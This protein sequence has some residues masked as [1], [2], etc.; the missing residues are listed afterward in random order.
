LTSTLVR[1]IGT[2]LSRCRRVD[3]HL[4]ALHGLL[5]SSSPTPTRVVP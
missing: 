2:R 4:F 5:Q 3:L 1:Y